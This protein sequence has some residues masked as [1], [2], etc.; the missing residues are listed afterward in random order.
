MAFPKVIKN[1]T[2][3]KYVDDIGLFFCGAHIAQQNDAINKDLQSLDNWL[4][5]NKLSL[6]VVKL[7][8]EYLISLKAQEDIRRI[9]LEK[10]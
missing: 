6:N 3:A 9:R 8:P 7:F 10:A 4:K 1:C 5:G 2:V